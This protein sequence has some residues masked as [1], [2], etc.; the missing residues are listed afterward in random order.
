MSLIYIV[1]VSD[2]LIKMITNKIKYN[3]K[4]LELRD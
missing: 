3:K 4:I 2:I 1:K